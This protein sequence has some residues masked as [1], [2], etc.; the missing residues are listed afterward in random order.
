MAALAKPHQGKAKQDRKQQNL[1]YLAACEGADHRVGNDVEE[2]IDALLGFRLLG[3]ASNFLRI[4]QGAAEARA[5]THQISDSEPD[6]QREG[7]YD[8]EIDQ[9]F[10]ADA[11]DLLGILDMRNTRDHRAEDDR[12]DHH[13]DQPDE[14]VAERL[15][16]VIFREIGP[17]RT[18]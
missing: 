13:L 7:R 3:E 5:G 15:D 17:E 2:E 8:L 18:N 6:D 11:A 9:R 10:D 14:A 1:Q 4:S 12:R 16:P